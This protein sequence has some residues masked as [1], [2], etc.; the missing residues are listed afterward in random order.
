MAEP[1][2]PPRWARNPHLQTILGSLQIRAAGRNEMA[3]ASRETVV[4]AGEGVRLQGFHARQQR[5]RPRGLIVLLHGWEGSA[6]SAYILSAG[7]FFFRR[8]FDVFRLN[9]R[10]HGDSHHL[11][12]GL[13]HGALTEEVFQAVRNIAALLPAGPVA[14][15]GFSLGGNFALRMAMEQG[16]RPIANLQQ[17]FCVSPALD[18]YKATLAIDGNLPLY[19]H[20]FLRKW[21]RSLLK[22]QRCFPE[23]YHFEA[24]MHHR[25]VMALTEAI[26]P[27]YSPFTSY[28]EY[29][30]RYTLTGD[31]LRA[32][33][34]PTTIFSAQDDPVVPAADFA[35][36]PTNGYLHVSLQRYGG[37]CGF[38]E[39]FPSGCW[40]EKQ[41][42]ESL[43]A[44]DRR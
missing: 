6:D 23:S 12:R 28:R 30:R 43:A 16:R 4:D 34:V 24:I 37:H 11:N 15:I 7:R 2:N 1:F 22:K 19:R 8:G 9:L 20:Y 41:I 32:V 27:C 21:K 39:R 13:F 10:D 26:I 38:M 29:F 40:Y 36:L 5:S 44:G 14:L 35:G 3:A 42:L 33:A 18:P 31:A 17:I 25:T